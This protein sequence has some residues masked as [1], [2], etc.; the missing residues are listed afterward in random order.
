MGSLRGTDAWVHPLVNRLP[1]GRASSPRR[2][3]MTPALASPAVVE[4]PTMPARPIF[5]L[6]GVTKAYQMGEVRVD[7]L[8]GVDVTLG[9]G[10]LVVL[11][12]P[13]GSGK[14]TLLNIIG[15]LDVPT[16]GRVWYGEQDLTTADDRTLT[17][18]RRH[19]VGFV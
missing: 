15:G 19:H 16:S 8:R 3:S 14:S 6:S 7:A 9:A 10:E 17:E 1:H 12:G 11:L 4:T 2:P 13:S 5:S 18:Y